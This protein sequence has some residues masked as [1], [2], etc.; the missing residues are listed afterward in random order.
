[1]ALNK[2]TMFK[3]LPR[4]LRRL[5][6]MLGMAPEPPQIDGLFTENGAPA[7]FSSSI[8]PWYKKC[9]RDN[10]A[11]S[12]CLVVEVVWYKKQNGAEHEFLRFNISS[13]DKVH[14]SIVIAERGGG[15]R[16]QNRDPSGATQPADTI[17]PIE[18]TG[19]VTPPDATVPPISSQDVTGDSTA[20]SA[21]ESSPRVDEA[22][23]TNGR[24]KPKT[25][26]S[27]HIGSISTSFQRSAHDLVNY[28]TLDSTASSELER[29]CKKATRD[30]VLT[31]P[32]GAGPSASQLATLLYVTSKHE[33]SYTL[34][35][36]QCYW[37]V[38]T[39]FDALK[40]L[41]AGAAQ[42][43]PKRRG[44]TWN[45]VPIPTKGGSVD[46]VC[47]KYRAARAALAEEA[48]QKR[49]AEQQQAEE[50]QR[51]RE[52]RLAAEARALAA[53]EQRQAA[54]E[55]RRAAEERARAAEEER[56]RER[57]TAEEERRRERQAAE[58]EIA[59]L[60]R[61]LEASRARAST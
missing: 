23:K 9:I 16:N 48:E 43:N 37:F 35:N 61:E 6:R 19:A 40:S 3:K 55:Q 14:T 17:A 7:F 46:V 24:P 38:E 54:E 1:M 26:P 18:T 47:A 2:K 30:C 50:R 13:P 22:T 42:D 51:E 20:S 28:A 21:D 39:V 29:R 10:P 15:V 11:T 49:K 34:T 27:A 57:Q 33:P 31:F 25:R 45:R 36:T 32:E 12:D 58:E 8:E 52:Q 56:R 53:E 60:R 5:T 41:F 4:F 59:K 44:G